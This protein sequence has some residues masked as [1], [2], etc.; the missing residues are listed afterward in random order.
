MADRNKDKSV[1]A[2]RQKEHAEK[3]PQDIKERN[4]LPAL[5]L[6]QKLCILL[7]A[8][9]CLIYANTAFNGYAYDDVMVIEKNNLVTQG[10]KAIPKILAT[11]HIYGYEVAASDVYRPLSLVM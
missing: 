10:M 4:P 5:S 1:A 2:I 9:A 6:K 11:P 3:S 8:A 7:A